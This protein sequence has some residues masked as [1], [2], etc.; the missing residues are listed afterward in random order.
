MYDTVMDYE[1]SMPKMLSKEERDKFIK[2]YDVI[3]GY[4]MRL[5]REDDKFRYDIT[6]RFDVLPNLYSS[7]AL[8]SIGELE[9]GFDSWIGNLFIK[10]YRKHNMMLFGDAESLIDYFKEVYFPILDAENTVDN[11]KGKNND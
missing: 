4:F 7:F 1:K 9:F 8:S 3:H 2:Y 11:L 10:D 6:F 5:I